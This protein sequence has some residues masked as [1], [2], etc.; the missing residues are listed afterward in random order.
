MLS[1]YALITPFTIKF[2]NTNTCMVKLTNCVSVALNRFNMKRQPSGDETTALRFSQ[3]SQ[4]ILVCL[5]TSNIK[6]VYLQ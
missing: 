4:P 1:W 2:Y 6:G 3:R 5:F